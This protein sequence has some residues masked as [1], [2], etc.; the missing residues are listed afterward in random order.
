[1]PARCLEYFARP[2]RNRQ[3]NIL[4]LY[5]LL[6]PIAPEVAIAELVPTGSN[7]ADTELKMSQ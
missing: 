4:F 1:M 5:L 7:L 3:S 2:S 6:D